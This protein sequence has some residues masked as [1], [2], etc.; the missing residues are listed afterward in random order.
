MGDGKWEGEEVQGRGGKTAW[1]MN[2]HGIVVAIPEQLAQELVSKKPGYKYTE[3]ED[4]PEQKQYPDDVMLTEAGEK[5]R[6]QIRKKQLEQQ[7]KIEENKKEIK[8]ENFQEKHAA[9]IRTEAKK[10]GLKHTHLKSIDTLEK[11]LVELDKN[12]KEE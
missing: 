7:V 11:E 3:P 4:V 5:R 8:E 9:E 1:I 10:R 6:I 12:E 2:P